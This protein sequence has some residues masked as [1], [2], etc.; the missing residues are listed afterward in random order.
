MLRI[1]FILPTYNKFQ[2]AWGAADSFSR[3]SDNALDRVLLVDDA[4]RSGSS[5][6][7]AYSGTR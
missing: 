3:Y 4:C 7:G 1:L 6:T 5:R 2:Y